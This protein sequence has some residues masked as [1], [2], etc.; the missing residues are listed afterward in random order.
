MGPTVV[1]SDRVAAPEWDDIGPTT[2]RHAP[3]RGSRGAQ[4]RWMRSRS[5]RT[6]P[7][8]TRV[9]S[10]TFC[11]FGEPAYRYGTVTVKCP[12]VSCG[13]TIRYVPDA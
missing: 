9:M 4:Y 10:D 1:G 3:Y 7:L 13:S 12:S 8:I 5:G 11:L 2:R 6:V